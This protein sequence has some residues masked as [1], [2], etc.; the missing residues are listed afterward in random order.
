MGK[1]P[2]QHQLSVWICRG[3]DGPDDKDDEEKPPIE[4]D[5]EIT[6]ESE[7]Q[8][9]FASQGFAVC[10]AVLVHRRTSES[11]FSFPLFIAVES[12]EFVWMNAR[13]TTLNCPG[14]TTI[15]K[16]K[17]NRSQRAEVLN[18]INPNV[19]RSHVLQASKCFEFPAVRIQATGFKLAQLPWQ[20]M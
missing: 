11:L 9:A 16:Q 8:V 19:F 15:F 5:E 6:G 10:P 18:L 2:A 12:C 1:V 4:R 13:S 3:G 14:S 7:S 20:Q 17:G